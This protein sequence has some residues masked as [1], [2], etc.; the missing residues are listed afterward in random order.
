MLLHLLQQ[1]LDTSKN[2]QM[3]AA[4]TTAGKVNQ[5]QAAE[6]L[7]PHFNSLLLRV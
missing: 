2:A 7:Q 3:N 6:Q 5:Q 1:C 4:W